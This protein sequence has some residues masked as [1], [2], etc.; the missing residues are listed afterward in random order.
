MKATRGEKWFYAF[1]YGIL[2]LLSISCLLPI[3]H[4]LSVSLSSNDSVM[5]GLV[6]FW[7]VEFTFDSYQ[8]LFDGTPIMRAFTNSVVITIVGTM[9]N[10][11]FTIMAAYPL[12]R[13][14]FYGRNLFSMAIVFTMLFSAGLIPNFL[15][16]RS[17]GLLDSYGALWLPG[18]VSA[19]NLLVLRS[20]FEN[21]PE[22]LVEAA[23]IDGCSEWG[24]LFRIFLPLSM[25]V[26]AALSLFYGVGHWNSFFNVLMYIN[27]S[28]KHN[29]SVLVQ[30]M[31]QN[32]QLLNEINNQMNMGNTSEDL[33]K[34]TPQSIRAAGI[35]VMVVPMLVVYPFL[36][37]FFVKGMLIG[38]I[39]G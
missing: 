32:Q 24:L 26:L 2:S 23:R 36:Q 7:P 1:N 13:K 28:T 37:K 16:I 4:L 34:I 25:P 3:I 19:W 31:I 35:M 20:F 30:N 11:T 17:L 8:L 12:S 39:K 14:Y 10:M 29:L 38:S 18:M 15:L 27:D 21:I 5:S 22:E 9:I 33:S 6:S